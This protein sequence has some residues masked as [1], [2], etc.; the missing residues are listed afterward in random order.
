MKKIDLGQTLNTLANIGVIAGIIFLA[1]EVRQNQESLDQANDLTRAAILSDGADK[2]NDWRTL[3]IQDPELHAIYDRGVDGE[4][5]SLEEARRFGPV[6]ANLFWTYAAT[7]QRFVL[8][9]DEARAVQGPGQAARDSIENPRQREC[10]ERFFD[11]ARGWGYGPFID[12]L[13]DDQLE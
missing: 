3:L 8:F 13:L 12:T 9:G 5:L 7:Y 6:C 10:W 4:E 1:I 11:M 2:F